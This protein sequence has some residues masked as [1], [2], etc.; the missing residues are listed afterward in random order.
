MSTNLSQLGNDEADPTAR[1]F[2]GSGRLMS[3]AERLFALDTGQ[4]E[5]TR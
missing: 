2:S 4:T 5:R 3:E 1:L